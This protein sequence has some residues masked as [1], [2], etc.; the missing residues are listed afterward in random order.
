MQADRKFK[1]RSLNILEIIDQA[2]RLYRRYFFKFIAII[3]V[4]Q[5]PT[6][7]LSILLSGFT[8]SGLLNRLN[9]ITYQDDLLSMFGPNFLLG[10]LGFVILGILGALL[11][12]LAQTTLMRAIADGYFGRSQG[13]FETY[14]DSFP[15]LGRTLLTMLL[16]GA[17]MFVYSIVYTLL[18]LIPCIG[19]LA[20]WLL[21]G[22]LLFF[23]TVLM[24]L[25][26]P[27]VVLEQQSITGSLRRVWDLVRSRFWHALGF[28]AVFVVFNVVA[29]GGPNVLVAVITQ[30]LSVAFF[31]SLG[32]SGAFLIPMI[33]QSLTSLMTNLIITP[34]YAVGSFLFYLDLRV[35]VEGLDLA[36]T[37]E[38]SFDGEIDPRTVLE[39]APAPC[40]DQLLTG[41]ELGYFALLSVG[42]SALWFVLM[43]VLSLLIFLVT[44]LATG[45]FS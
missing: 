7:L 21:M 15:I 35:R 25:L 27:V 43:L 36:L 5:V 17:L 33:V 8:F 26:F 19:W 44:A 24:P 2:I 42:F 10:I 4:A 16:A 37:A 20:A 30:A 12:L 1:L 3:A 31:D 34:L 6:V 13:V 9:A 11:S 39:Q 23:F 38:Q 28:F 22:P 18:A 41:R 40:S 29:I 32:S 45:L 14:R